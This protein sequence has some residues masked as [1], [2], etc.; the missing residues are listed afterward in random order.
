MEHNNIL[1][2]LKESFIEI[3][4]ILKKGNTGEISNNVGYL[5]KSGDYINNMDLHSNHIIKSHLIKCNEVWG[6]ASEEDEGIVSRFSGQD[7]CHYFVSIDPLD[8]S[9]NVDCN[10]T[11]G[12]IFTIF[13]TQEGKYPSSGRS[14]VCAGY[15]L[16][17]QCT[18]FVVADKE[19]VQIFTLHPHVKT[20]MKEGDI[21]VP[22]SG[23]IYSINE[24][25]RN[26]WLDS[27]F[28]KLTTSLIEKNYTMR[29]VGS[30]VADAHRTLLKGGFFSYPADVRNNDGRIRL[31]YEAYP[32]AYI[33]D[34]ANGYSSDGN[35]N[36]LDVRFPNDIHKKTPVFL[37][38]KN[39]FNEFM[40]L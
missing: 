10:I 36:I 12:S 32:F 23:C 3:S 21:E 35:V 22:D 1:D 18:Q 13:D 11:V 24:S 16:Y 2:A 5:N 8:G 40:N 33:F 15:C 7:N 28:S 37:S 34:K 4:E 19:G 29:W 25:N 17:G 26:R 30:M 9:S 6:I 31:V 14:I 39:E 27:R 38:G 20:F